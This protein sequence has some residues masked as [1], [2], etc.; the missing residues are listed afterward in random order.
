MILLFR[1]VLVDH[2]VVDL[3]VPNNSPADK[4]RAANV[5]PRLVVFFAST[6]STH[7]LPSKKCL[8]DTAF[9]ERFTLQV[10]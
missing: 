8:L 9:P 6:E 1:G 5:M 4:Q 10:S 3:K 2:R 7:G